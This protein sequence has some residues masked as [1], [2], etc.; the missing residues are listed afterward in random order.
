M[1]PVPGTHLSSRYL[2]QDPYLPPILASPLAL[3]PLYL[4]FLIS[5]YLWSVIFLFHP[6]ASHY[7]GCCLGS[8]DQGSGSAVSVFLPHSSL[9]AGPGDGSLLNF[10]VPKRR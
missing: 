9:R 1:G 2:L 3:R 4:A 10:L 5:R 7:F 6:V 8:K